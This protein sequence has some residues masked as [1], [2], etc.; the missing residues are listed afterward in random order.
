MI[1]FFGYLV[2]SKSSTTLNANSMKAHDIASFLIIGRSM[3]CHAHNPRTK[4]K[5]KIVIANLW[6]RWAAIE[7]ELISL[8]NRKLKSL[9]WMRRRYHRLRSPNASTVLSLKSVGLSKLK[10]I[11]GRRRAPMLTGEVED[12]RWKGCSRGEC[13]HSWVSDASSLTP[14]LVRCMTLKRELTRPSLRRPP[15]RQTSPITFRVKNNEKSSH[16]FSCACLTLYYISK[17]VQ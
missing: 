1:L 10:I 2:Q 4:K 11:F 9:S 14:S 17:H 12:D 13:A 8:W 15:D 7:S 16:S 6:I 5:I 3:S